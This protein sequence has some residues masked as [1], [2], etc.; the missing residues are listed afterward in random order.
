MIIK[1]RLIPHCLFH[2]KLLKIIFPYNFDG[3]QRRKKKKE[4]K[5]MVKTS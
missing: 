1:G 2:M 3:K 4:E 5:E